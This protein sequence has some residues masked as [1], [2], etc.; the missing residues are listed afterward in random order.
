M[1]ITSSSSTES[2]TGNNQVPP[3]K[4]VG[5]PMA[6]YPEPLKAAV[7][8]YERD[9]LALFPSK[10]GE[11]ATEAERKKDSEAQFFEYMRGGACKDEF[12]A[13]EDCVVE[14][15]HRN[16]KCHEIYAKMNN[17]MRTH[18]HYYQP[19]R[20]RGREEFASLGG[21]QESQV[22]E[23]KVMVALSFLSPIKVTT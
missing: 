22:R 19:F 5:D 11:S 7:Y 6:D 9:L 4:L 23:A 8:K 21:C 1:G 15:G 17:C 3:E 20:R 2:S 12:N 14:S 16:K 10:L 13:H 18:H